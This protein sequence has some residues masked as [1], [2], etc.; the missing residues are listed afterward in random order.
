MVRT[1]TDLFPDIEKKIKKRYTRLRLWEEYK[2]QYHY[3][4]GLSQSKVI[5]RIWAQRVNAKMHI[6][7]KA[8]DKMY[9]DF[10]GDKLS[11][12]DPDTGEVY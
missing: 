7:H 6:E 4:Y 10:A 12:V 5:Y 11:Y 9:V 1:L 8:G 2:A 3:G